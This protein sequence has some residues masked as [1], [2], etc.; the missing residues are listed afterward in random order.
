PR[1]PRAS[2]GERRMGY[3]AILVHVDADADSDPRVRLARELAARCK[4]TLIG[5]GAWA[6]QSLGV[7]DIAGGEDQGSDGPDFVGGEEPDKPQ[8]EEIAGWLAR[9]GQHFRSIAG[10][11]VEWRSAMD[12]PTEFVVP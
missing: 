8:V 1:P 11:T 9:L 5:A 6:L 12:F 2:M 4:A 3:A 7:G 10:H